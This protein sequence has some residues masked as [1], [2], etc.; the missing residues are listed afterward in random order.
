MIRTIIEFLWR[1]CG[2]ITL[3]S[4]VVIIGTTENLKE[5]FFIFMKKHRIISAIYWTMCFLGLIYALYNASR[6]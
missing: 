4:I 5:K 1:M 2:M 6:Y 3:T